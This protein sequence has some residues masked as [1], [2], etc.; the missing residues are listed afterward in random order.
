VLIL[1][2]VILSNLFVQA[3]I[4]YYR[5]NFRK[6]DETGLFGDETV[7]FIIFQNKY[8]AFFSLFIQQKYRLN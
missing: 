3:K 1:Y 4:N 5:N 6:G 2:A 7:D 8:S